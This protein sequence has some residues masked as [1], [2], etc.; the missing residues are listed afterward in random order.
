MSAASAARQALTAA[1]LGLAACGGGGGPSGS[2][3]A[4]TEQ[5]LTQLFNLSAVY[6]RLGRLASTG[7]IPFVGSVAFV[8]GRGDSTS[9]LLG[10]SFENR[11]LS[12]QRDGGSF[13]ARYRVYRMDGPR[14]NGP[15]Q[16]V[17]RLTE[18]PIDVANF[19]DETK[20]TDTKRYWIVAVDKLGQEG[21]PSAPAWGWRQYRKV[22]E[23]FTGEWHQ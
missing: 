15:G 17:V 11:M 14:V 2:P 9:V 6:Q 22:Y 19:T 10:I 12:F 13:A 4:Q 21:I 23:A 1:L 8:A 3:S 18:K 20:S 5:T 16:K 7:P